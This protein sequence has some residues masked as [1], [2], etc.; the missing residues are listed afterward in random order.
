MAEQPLRQ[1]L[2][3]LAEQL[4][5]LETEWIDLLEQPDACQMPLRC[6]IP[7]SGRKTAALLLLVA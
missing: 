5:G 7:G 4:Q 2:S 6:S 3:R 1:A